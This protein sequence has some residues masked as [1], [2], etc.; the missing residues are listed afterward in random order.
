MLLTV[1]LTMLGGCAVNAPPAVYVH[2]VSPPMH[3]RLHADVTAPIYRGVALT[4]EEAE[5]L[6]NSISEKI[7]RAKAEEEY[8]KV[9]LRE[10]A[11][12]VSDMRR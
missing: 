4:Q 9:R 2:P 8:M 10:Y 7:E 1:T 12:S 6:I 11:D 5:K 3:E